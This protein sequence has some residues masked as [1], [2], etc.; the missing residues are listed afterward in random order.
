LLSLSQVLELI[1]LLSHPGYFR[2][3]EPWS[4][5]NKLT[6]K[7]FELSNRLLKNNTN[8]K[9][10]RRKSINANIAKLSA[11]S[12]KSSPRTDPTSLVPNTPLNYLSENPEFSALGSP[13]RN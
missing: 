6:E 3:F 10:G 7:Q 12:L 1:A 8:L 4:N 2:I 5:E 11:T 9:I 13:T